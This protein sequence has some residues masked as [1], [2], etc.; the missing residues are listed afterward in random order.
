LGLEVVDVG[1]AMAMLIC[2]A[3]LSGFEEMEGTR[4]STVIRVARKEIYVMPPHQNAHMWFH[5]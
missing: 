4:K 2:V 3:L 1:S 5:G